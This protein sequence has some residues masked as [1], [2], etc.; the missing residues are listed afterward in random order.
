MKI[1]INIPENLNEITIGQYQRFLTLIKNNEPSDFVSKKTIEILCDCKDAHLLPYFEI[2][3]IL[4]QI[5]KVFESKPKFMQRFDDFG[6]IPNLDTMTFGEYIDLNSYIDK[7][8]DAHKAM[9]VLYRPIVNKFKD[10]YTIEKYEGSDKYSEQMKDAPLGVYL[11][12]K[13]FF[14]NLANELLSSTLK[15]LTVEERQIIQINLNLL[16]DGDGIQVSMH[17]LGEMLQNLIVLQN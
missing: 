2:E 3:D 1:E 9:A 14:Y 17:S 5:N 10:L 7:P 8:E 11:G 4:N 15:S 16:Q 6:F 13:V 12:A